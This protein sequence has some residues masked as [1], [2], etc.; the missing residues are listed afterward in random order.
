M[1]FLHLTW[2]I[3]CKDF[4]IILLSQLFLLCQ[5][6]VDGLSNNL[7]KCSL[8]LA[9]RIAEIVHIFCSS[10]VFRC[11]SFRDEKSETVVSYLVSALNNFAIN[12]A[13][14][15]RG[16]LCILGEDLFPLLLPLFKKASLLVKVGI[17]II[18]CYTDLY[19][20]LLARTFRLDF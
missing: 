19:T 9:P 16:Q 15:C 11:L 3:H 1:K 13:A 14:D 17:Q 18:S 12:I 6:F 5:T 7:F 4:S 20:K 8:R 2:Y 10:G